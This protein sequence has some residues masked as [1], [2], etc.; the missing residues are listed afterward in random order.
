MYIN[1]LG[2]KEINAYYSRQGSRRTAHIK[3][4]ADY[5]NAA[6]TDKTTATQTAD[7]ENT[8]CETCR[9]TNQLL[10]R[11][12][13]NQLYAPNALNGMGY[14]ATGSGALAAYQSLSKYLGSNLFN[15]L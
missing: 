8:C 11:L 5:M 10:L 3:N 12:L 6:K 9:R 14:S 13:S 4:F 15:L 2:I 7:S 1:E